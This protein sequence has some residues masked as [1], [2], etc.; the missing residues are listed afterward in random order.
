[1]TR[2][3]RFAAA[4]SAA[5]LCAL[6]PPMAHGAD[7][8]GG[9]QARAEA[10]IDLVLAPD[11]AAA[12]SGPYGA[13]TVRWRADAVRASGLRWGIDVAADA[14]TGDGRRGLARVLDDC[15]SCPRAPDGRAL[16]GLITGL[17]GEARRRAGWRTGRPVAGVPLGADR[18]CAPARRH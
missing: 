2:S 9:L 16:A 10:D 14:V 3:D 6:A 15:P 12:R 13:L 4:C 11:S 5:A 7:L 8:P 1:M 18:L 17:S